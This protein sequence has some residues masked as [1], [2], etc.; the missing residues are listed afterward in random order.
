MSNVWKI[1]S[2]WGYP[3]TSILDVFLSYN[4]VFFNT[5]E[6]SKIGDYM[7]VKNGDLFIIADGETPVAIAKALD[8]FKKYEESGLLFTSQDKDDYIYEKVLLCKVSIILLEKEERKTWGFMNQNRFCAY[9]PHDLAQRELVF[10][11]WEEHQS[12]NDHGVF[13]IVCGTYS[14]L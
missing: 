13:D 8:S 6:T 10:K 3:G 12:K 7:S 5:D 9:R 4:C 2:R 11:Y 1:G 14:L